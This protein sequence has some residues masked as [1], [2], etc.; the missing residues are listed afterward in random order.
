MAHRVDLNWLAPVS[1]SAPTGY[2]VYRKD[3]GSAAAFALIGSS[4]T[5]TFTDNDPNFV[6][7]KSYDYE[8]TAFNTI[9]E[10]VPSAAVS[11]TI[12]FLVPDAPT[13]LVA[14]AH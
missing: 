3:T 14:E 8:V 12:P 11:A 6:E 7:G 2:N 13:D 1:G 10:S 5:L 9:G 4:A